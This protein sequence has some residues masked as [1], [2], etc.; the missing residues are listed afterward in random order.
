MELMVIMPRDIEP[1]CLFTTSCILSVKI[2]A[3]NPFFGGVF[4]GGFASRSCCDNMNMV[5][6]CIRLPSIL[7][8]L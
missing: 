2:N 1:S 6:K 7:R 5:K 3:G 8:M 4:S